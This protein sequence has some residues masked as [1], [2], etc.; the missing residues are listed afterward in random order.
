MYTDELLLNGLNLSLVDLYQVAVHGQKV[1]LHPDAQIALERS[2]EVIENSLRSGAMVYGV[3][4]G[5]GYLKNQRINLQNIQALQRNL[6]LSHAAGVGE[7][8][9]VPISRA[10]TLLRANTLLRGYSGVRPVV[11]ERL[12]DMLNLHIHPV[13]PSQGSVG[14]SGD[15]APLAHLALVLIGEGDVWH[16]EKKISGRKALRDHHLKPLVL[17]AKEGLALI[18]GTQPMCAIAAL[19]AHRMKEL[20]DLADMTAALTVQS[21]MGS[22]MPFRPDLHRLRPHPG[23]ITSATNLWH[24]LQNSEI[25]DS[26]HN[27]DH[28]QDAYSLRCTPQVHGASRD[29]WDYLSRV[30]TIEMNSVTDNPLVLPDSEEVIS[31]GHFHGQ[32]LALALD[33]TGIALAEIANIAERRIER[34]VNPQLSRGL[35]AF[36]TSEGGLHSGYMIAQY[37]AA[38]LVSENKV[39]AHPASVDSIPTS[40]NQEDHVS[41]GTIAANKGWKILQH[42]EQV[43]AIEL[44]CACQALDFLQPLKPSPTTLAV[45]QMVRQHLPHLGPDRVV[46]KDIETVVK[47]IRQADFRD[48]IATHLPTT[49]NEV[50]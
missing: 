21:T 24:W 1:A 23:Q 46:S 3:N 34:M 9:S 6:I 14:S 2:R 13:I 29:A 32:P 35:P 10:I 22:R 38:A 20:L 44:M 33:L 50:Y 47:L 42:T 49:A 28:V 5:F 48:L 11:V 17:Q 18:N 41:M 26:H 4:T 7:P 45:Y 36:L 8:F 31:C 39:L 19:T 16:G 40:G 27:C 30:V 43:L 15:L 25:M 37:V 12:L